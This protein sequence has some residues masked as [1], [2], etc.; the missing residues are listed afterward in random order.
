MNSSTKKL[1]RF[2]NRVFLI[3]YFKYSKLLT[4]TSTTTTTL[5]KNGTMMLSCSSL[6]VLIGDLFMFACNF[7]EI[8]LLILILL[9]AFYHSVPILVLIA[10][11]FLGQLFYFVLC[12]SKGFFTHSYLTEKKVYS[13]ILKI[14]SFIILKNRLSRG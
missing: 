6:K 8:F 5:P 12:R 2:L 4:S 9:Y 11:G 13:T 14:Y 3:N 7:C 1:K 10:V